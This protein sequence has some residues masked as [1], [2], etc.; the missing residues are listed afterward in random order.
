M[1]GKLIRIGFVVIATSGS[2]NNQIAVG[3]MKN[4]PV[5]WRVVYKK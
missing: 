2:S 5:I 4:A 3:Y 1:E